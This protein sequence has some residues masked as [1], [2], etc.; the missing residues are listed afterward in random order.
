MYIKNQVDT[1]GSQSSNDTN[2]K[3]NN[4]ISLLESY[5]NNDINYSIP[6]RK[7]NSLEVIDKN[8]LKNIHGGENYLYS[9]L[10]TIFKLRKIPNKLF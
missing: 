10:K 9:I 2:L 4:I 5:V 8:D 7:N 6:K 3:T 1:T